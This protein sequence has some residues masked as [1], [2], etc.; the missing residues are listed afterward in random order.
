MVSCGSSVLCVVA[1]LLA[2]GRAYVLPLPALPMTARMLATGEAWDG[3]GKSGQEVQ[4]GRR[5]RDGRDGR[6]GRGSRGSR[7]SRGDR[8]DHRGRGERGGRGGRGGRGRGDPRS[9]QL[10]ELRQ[11][12]HRGDVARLLEQL[13]PRDVKE[14]SMGIS[15]YGRSRDWRSALSLLEEMRAA[16][17][18]P[19][20]IS[21]NAAISACGKG[22]RWE[23]ALSL[24]EEMRAAGVAPDVIS[25]N[26]AISACE[27]GGRW[28]RA[29]SLLE[30][31]RAE[32]V[33]PDVISFSAAISACA[34]GG[35]W[36]RA[37]LLFEEVEASS[38][39][40]SDIGTFNAILD[41][42]AQS[43]PPAARE[44]WQLGV[45][46]GVY[47][48]FERWGDI[49]T[50]DLHNLSEGAATVAVRWW[51]EERVPSELGAVN[52]GRGALREQ[53]LLSG[54]K[55]ARIPARIDIVTGWGKSR[56]AYQSGDVRARVIALL[57]VM[58]VDFTCPN[59]NPGLLCV[60]NCQ[61]SS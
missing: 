35:Q 9:Q 40:V 38:T 58:S 31:M 42:M 34:K 16:G 39:L 29:L 15:A 46:R 21:F 36:E 10:F 57:E 6:G 27:K 23:R 2:T 30:E 26:A 49:P 48:G 14:Y 19:N 56:Q 45:D 60:Q 12:R 11:T 1:T 8:G 25:F 53:S 20:V 18:A 43:Q 28:E 5:G 17:V 51:I 33:A 7:G 24:L 41:A 22:G 54:N 47:S 61:A 55:T 13:Q 3:R 37:L 59:N 32:G 44:L 52:R 50:L 4:G